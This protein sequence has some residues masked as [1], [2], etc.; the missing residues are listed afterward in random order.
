MQNKIA[1]LEILN[2]KID[3]KNKKVIE[4]NERLWRRTRH[5]GE[6]AREREM[7]RKVCGH[8]FY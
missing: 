5:L 2:K 3:T 8:F 1:R 4:H 7:E 6:T